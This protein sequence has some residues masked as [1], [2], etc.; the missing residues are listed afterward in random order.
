MSDHG[1]D[2]HAEHAHDSHGHEH[3]GDYNLKPPGPSTLPKVGPEALFIF[4]MALTG[5]LAAISFFSVRLST[6]APKAHHEAHGTA[7]HA[8]HHH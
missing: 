3:W 8:D 6:S 4:G 5:M 2:S 1:H 7:D